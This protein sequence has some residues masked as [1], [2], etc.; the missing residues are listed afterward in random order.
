M[1]KRAKIRDLV[2]LKGGTAHVARLCGVSSASV[3]QWC[4]A[5]S[6]PAK[7][8]LVLSREWHC[9]PD[10][11][12]NPWGWRVDYL[13]ESE[14][15]AALAGH[16]ADDPLGPVVMEALPDDYSED[17]DPAWREPVKKKVGWT[18]DE[19]AEMFGSED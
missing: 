14:L 5:G 15:H 17:D 7:H 2:K 18:E 1:Y 16:D 11:L 10:I 6:I 13:T 8:A 12:H 19:I 3:S 4:G 9:N